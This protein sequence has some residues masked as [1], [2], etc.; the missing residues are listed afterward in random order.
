MLKVVE[1]DGWLQP[2]E[3]TLED[4]QMRF[5]NRLGAIASEYGSITNYS[6][7]YRYFGFNYDAIRKGWW[8]R[9]WLPRAYKVFLFGDFNDWNRYGNELTR[10]GDDGVWEL[11]F[12]DSEYR[13]RLVHGSK[14]KMLVQAHGQEFDRLPA[15]VTRVMQNDSTKVYD[16]QFWNP[17]KFDWGEDAWV[18]N[19]EL[20]IYE[21]HIG[22]AQERLGYGTYKEFEDILLP[23]IKKLGYNAL[24]IMAVAEHPYYGSFGYHVSNFFAPSSKFGTPEELKSLIRRAHQMGIT[25][26]MDIVHSHFVSNTNEGIYMLDGYDGLYSAGDHPYW[27]SKL[28][29]YG[30]QEVQRFLLSN[31]RYWLE[32]FHFDGFRFDGVSSML[33]YHHGY[34]DFGSYD[35]YFGNAVNNDSILYLMLANRLMKDINPISLSIAEDV[36]GMPTLC[37]SIEDGGMGFDYRLAMSV[38]DHWIKL[39]KEYKDEDWNIGE[40]WR[41]HVDRLWTTK[42]VAYCES[43]DQALVG[44][45]TIAFWLMDSE[46]YKSMSKFTESMIIDRGIALHK[47]IRMFTISTGGQAYLNFMGNEYGHPDWIDFPRQGN[48]WSFQYARRQWSLLKDTTLKYEY[49]YLF[50]K[51]MIEFIKEHQLLEV[52]FPELL[53]I[54]E[55]DKVI[56]FRL[57]LF[58]FV[59]NWNVDKSFENYRIPVSERG[60]YSVILNSDDAKFGGFNRITGDSLHISFDD[61]QGGVY[62]LTYCINRA[63]IVYKLVNQA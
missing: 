57:G 16:A 10:V 11:F 25:V 53:Y 59:F 29:D 37:S 54:H 45:K 50:D 24:Q 61:G 34:S 46:M 49:L 56:A 33:Y 42:C 31:V 62:I 19:Y 20:F 4:R 6:E 18:A 28:F 39:L 22:M 43:H 1:Q 40:L 41:I 21:C 12:S 5:E 3:R 55:D 32:E 26:I 30:K 48:N 17:P 9:E 58:V 38:P 36:S 2:V 7:A 44:D 47:M 15:F 35:S 63:V 51:A 8:F 60:D 13:D 23:Y 14:Y 52:G 27:G